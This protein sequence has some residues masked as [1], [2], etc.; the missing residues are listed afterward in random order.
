M[1]LRHLRYFV[2]IAEELNFT[3]AAARLRVA[4]PALSSQIKDLEQELQAVL[5][6]RGRT[7]VQLTRAGKAFYPRARSILRQAAEAANEARSAAG[8]ITGSLVVGF[9]SGLHLSF[10]APAIHAYHKAHPRVSL[11]YFHGLNGQQ[12]KALRDGRL[13]IAFI[14]L[15]ATLDGYAQQVIWRTP[16]KVVLPSKHPLAKRRAFDLGDLRAEDFVFCTRESRPEFYDEFYR[17]CSNAGFRPRVVKEVGGYPT[18]MLGLISVGVG[19]SVL[20]HFEG[21]ERIQGLVWRTLS[22]PKLW[23]DF[24]LVW[25]Q[26]A[27]SPVV[28]EFVATARKELPVVKEPERAEL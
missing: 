26:P 14:T 9:L 24:A 6:E 7:G 11:D 13:D 8:T 10:L 4:Q 22:K 19:I 18:N 17:Q 23:T 15:P 5:F 2:A 1:E 16:F 20:P 21:V 25:R 28:A 3:H 27:T 12:L